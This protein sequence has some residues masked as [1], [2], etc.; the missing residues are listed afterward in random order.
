MNVT[1]RIARFSDWRTTEQRT[2][3]D[4]QERTRAFMRLEEHEYNRRW[5][6]YIERLRRSLSRVTTPIGAR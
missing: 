3:W 2:E 4:R 6:Q 1:V 5:A